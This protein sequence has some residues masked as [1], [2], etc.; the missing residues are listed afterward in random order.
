MKIILF[1]L[2]ISFFVLSIFSQ[3]LR[4][5][6]LPHQPKKEETFNQNV[7]AKNIFNLNAVLKTKGKVS[8][9]ISKNSEKELVFLGTKIW[10]YKV[11]QIDTDKVLL[12]RENGKT[13]ILS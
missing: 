2:S 12:T 6:F 4:N 10:G 13:L 1:S 8:A 11:A 5:P 9:I 3:N 7:N